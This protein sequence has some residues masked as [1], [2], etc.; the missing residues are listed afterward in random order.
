MRIVTET[1]AR[2]DAPL[3][4]YLNGP[5]EREAEKQAEEWLAGHPAGE[6]VRRGRNWAVLLDGEPY[7][8]DGYG[9]SPCDGLPS[10]SLAMLMQRLIAAE[11]LGRCPLHRGE[12]RP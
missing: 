10:W 2:R 11:T 8:G 5:A 3:F 6:I 1:P 9:G 7:P 4:G 12:A